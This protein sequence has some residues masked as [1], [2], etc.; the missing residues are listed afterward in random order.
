MIDV[1]IFEGHL[2]NAVE[3]T[4]VDSELRNKL[5]EAFDIQ[6]DEANA[7]YKAAA[8]EAVEV[9]VSVVNM[10]LAIRKSDG[11]RSTRMLCDLVIS[12][13]TNQFWVRNSAALVPMLQAA[14]FAYFDEAELAVEKHTNNNYAVYDGL[15]CGSRCFP[16]SI[17]SYVMFLLAGPKLAIANSLQVKKFLYPL[18]NR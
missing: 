17:V 18:F 6:N 10:F 2:G 7:G 13:N 14:L 15:I 16:L 8:L 9:C 4:V 1:G 5:I 12:L 11:P 3:S